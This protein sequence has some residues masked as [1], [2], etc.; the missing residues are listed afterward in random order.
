MIKVMIVDDEPPIVRS[1]KFLIESTNMG[2]EVVS[3]GYNGSEAISMLSTAKPDLI[4]TDIRMPVMDGLELLSYVRENNPEIITVILTGFQEFEYAKKALQM[5]VL[6]YLLKPVSAASIKEVLIK[7]SNVFQKRSAEDESRYIEALLNR[8]D[9]SDVEFQS[10][11]EYTDFVLI[12]I[13]A[14]SLPTIVMDDL[15][16]ARD[17]WGSIDL[18]K[19]VSAVVPPFIKTWV[20][21]G[22]SNAEYY[23]LF[24]SKY[25]IEKYIEECVSQITKQLDYGKIALTAL[26]SPL[27]PNV[28]L[29]GTE[30]QTL[31]L[32]LVRHIKIGVSQTLW[33]NKIDSNIGA[34]NKEVLSKDSAFEK[35]LIASMQQANIQLFKSELEKLFGHWEKYQYPQLL[36]ERLLKMLIVEC[37]R[38]VYHSLSDRI[39][40]L[41]LEINQA[42]ANSRSYEELFDGIWYFFE[43]LFNKKHKVESEKENS[44][45]IMKKVEAYIRENY[46]ESIT[47]QTL[48][49]LFGLVPSYLSKLF[50]AYKGMSPSEH[51]TFLRMERAK[52]LMDAHFD[53]LTK[54]IAQTVGYSDPHYFSRIFKKEIGVW[55]S[56]YRNKKE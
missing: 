43:E 32:N 27:V 13:C 19:K 11:L 53:M 28:N 38:S 30:A 40:S 21:D 25:D 15:I 20:I 7:V 29:L 17:F 26:I 5:D 37:Y 55:P 18:E 1:I 8:D 4:I 10:T 51:L 3:C 48:A 12:L 42:L 56:D 14:G 34:I 16:P 44:V 36:V 47:H 2:F 46:T 23:V 9:I 50:K 31:R 41:E 22:K 33:L 24:A 52:E 49:D 35:S 6:D 54:D 39:S 45:V